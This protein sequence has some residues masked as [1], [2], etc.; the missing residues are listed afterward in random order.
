MCVWLGERAGGLGHAE[1][2]WLVHCTGHVPSVVV[3]CFVNCGSATHSGPCADGRRRGAG[4]VK[5]AVAV[6]MMMCI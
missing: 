3:V 1:F 5:T 2:T 6:A 4:G